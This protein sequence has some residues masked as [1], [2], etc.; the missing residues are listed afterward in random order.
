M[1]YLAILICAVMFA[2]VAMTVNEGL[3]NNAISL[4][5]VMLGGLFGIFVGV[6][7]GIMIGERAGATTDNA[8][9]F[10][11]AGVWGVFALSVLIIRLIMDRTSRTR[12]KFIPLVDKFGGPLIGIL[13]ATMFTSFA[14]Y[15]L[16]RIPIKAG[17]WSYSD[18]G[19]WEKSV[20]TYARAPF[21]NLA[22][23]FT[24]GQGLDNTFVKQ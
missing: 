22:N 8:W 14:A 20:F 12:M 24:A 4:L 15:T 9:Y 5:S 17:A 3:W 18:A 1:L 2:G 6:P 21:Y 16:D 10:V 11:F 7:A 23:A 13:V 19:A